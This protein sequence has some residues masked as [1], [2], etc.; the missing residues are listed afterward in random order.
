MIR[1]DSVGVPTYDELVIVA[2]ERDLRGR[3]EL[4][5]RFMRALARG[6]EALRGDLDAGLDPLLAANRDLTRHLQLASLKATLPAFFPSGARPFGY[7]DPTQWRSYATWMRDNGLVERAPDA[8]RA[9]TNEFLPGEGLA[10]IGTR[11]PTP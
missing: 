8:G 3:G 4:V 5:R 9:L 1:V 10:G 11:S 2:R 7:M 6:H